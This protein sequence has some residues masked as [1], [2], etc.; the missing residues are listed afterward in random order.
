MRRVTDDDLRIVR[1]TLN[2]GHGDVL[3]EGEDISL[4]EIRRLIMERF[5]N[6]DEAL[7]QLRCV[8]VEMACGDK[9]RPWRFMNDSPPRVVDGT[10]YL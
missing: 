2:S 3:V 9:A 1:A 8:L 4:D 5:P 7:A 10:I 6:P